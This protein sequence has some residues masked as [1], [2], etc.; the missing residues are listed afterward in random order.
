MYYRCIRFNINQEKNQ[1]RDTILLEQKESSVLKIGAP[2][3]SVHRTVHMSTSHSREFQG[4][5]RYKSPDCP[6]C[7]RTT[8]IQRQWSTAKVPATVSSARQSQSSEVIVAL[9]CP[10]PQEDKAS[11]GRP[12]PNPNG[13]VMW[14]RTGQGTLS[15]RWRTRMSGAPIASSLPNGYGSGWGL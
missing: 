10:V 1:V 12:A 14:R 9:D 6:V 4:A 11:N 7:H 3:C 8:A 2:D 13:W 5:L 15:V